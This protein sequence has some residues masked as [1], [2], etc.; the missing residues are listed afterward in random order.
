MFK[1]SLWRPAS[2]CSE[3]GGQAG[4]E[5][6]PLPEK[7]RWAGLVTP[8][9]GNRAAGPFITGA[10]R[11]PAAGSCQSSKPLGAFLPLASPAPGL[12]QGDFLRR[13]R[14]EGPPPPGVPGKCPSS[15]VESDK[16]STLDAPPSAHRLEHE[17]FLEPPGRGN[18]TQDVRVKLQRLTAWQGQGTQAQSL[19]GQSTAERRQAPGVPLGTLRAP[20]GPLCIHDLDVIPLHLQNL[21]VRCCWSYFTDE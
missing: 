17:C 21:Q 5:G 7:A 14:G 16:P 18:R 6:A 19:R 2:R 9:S 1:K 12:C 10:H 15:A 20:C 13:Q 3:R 11:P 4:A 8:G